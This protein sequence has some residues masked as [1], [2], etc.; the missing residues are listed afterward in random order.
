MDE[1]LA[2]AAHLPDA[3]VGPL[4]GLADELKQLNAR[5][6]PLRFLGTPRRRAI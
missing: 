5:C 3:I 2:T 1:V 4:P 6:E